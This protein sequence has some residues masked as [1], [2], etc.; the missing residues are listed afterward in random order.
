MSKIPAFQF[1]P[2]D[3]R[4]DIGVQSLTYHDRGVWFEILCL[5]H[6]SEQRGRLLLNGKPM[7][8]DV[9]TRILGLDKQ[10]LDQA[11]ERILSAG[12]ADIISGVLTNRRM[13]RDE[14]I[15]KVR[16]E[17]GILGGNPALLNQTDNQKPSKP[18]SK[19]QPLHLQS[20][21]S[22]SEEK[23]EKIVSERGRVGD[24][25]LETKFFEEVT[26]G[27]YERMRINTFPS[28]ELPAWRDAILWALENNFTAGAV[29]ETYDLLKQQKFRSGRITPKVLQ[30]N[31]PELEKIK[32]ELESEKNG[33]GRTRIQNNGGD[34]KNAGS[35]KTDTETLAGLGISDNP[36]HDVRR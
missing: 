2:A 19:S 15:R 20:S 21:S 27:L 36:V 18:P 26:H 16:R 28:L 22:S 4:K 14:H 10:K 9:L 6:E 3:W 32:A 12:V 30:T 5:M 1:Y 25:P 29:L 13:V 31:L 24:H 8:N 7:P 17:S 34:T 11:L 35:A 33:N 23:K